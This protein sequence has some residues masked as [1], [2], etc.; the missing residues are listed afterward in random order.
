M[1]HQSVGLIQGQLEKAG[2][3]SITTTVVP[4]VT[5]GMKVSRA[6]YVRFPI[7]NPFGEAHNKEQQSAVLDAVL[8]AFEAIDTPGTLVELPF[9]WRRPVDHFIDE[10]TADL[11]PGYVVGKEYAS[12]IRDRYE[13]LLQACYDYRDRLQEVLDGLDPKTTNPKEIFLV[14]VH[15]SRAETFIDFLE[16]PVDAQVLANTSRYFLIQLA[17]EGTFR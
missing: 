3:P 9:R 14:N 12:L 6:A 11:A 8:T 15:K 1:C 7:G 13:D 4:Y 2:I 5:R 17:H 10:A 16:K